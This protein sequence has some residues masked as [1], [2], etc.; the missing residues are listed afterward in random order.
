M[1]SFKSNENIQ[2]SSWLK[3]LGRS[4]FSLQEK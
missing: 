1:S 4:D 3:I 2:G